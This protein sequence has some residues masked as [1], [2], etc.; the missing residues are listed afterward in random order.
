[1]DNSNFRSCSM[2]P[3]KLKSNSIYPSASGCVDSKIA[4][5]LPRRPVHLF[6]QSM[7]FFYNVFHEKGLSELETNGSA[8]FRSRFRLRVELTRE[9]SRKTSNTGSKIYARLL[10]R[11]IYGIASETQMLPVE[12]V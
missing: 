10:V 4:P 11:R 5:D 8:S 3:Q 9:N 7:N 12:A 6:W 1:M 2:I